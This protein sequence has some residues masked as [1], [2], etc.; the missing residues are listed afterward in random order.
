MNTDWIYSC[1]CEIEVAA[2]RWRDGEAEFE[3]LRQVI[4]EIVERHLRLAE[5]LEKKQ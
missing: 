4:A 5:R 2:E 3:D 1:A